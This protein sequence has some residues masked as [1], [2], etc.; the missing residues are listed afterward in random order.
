MK[1]S[2]R[3]KIPVNQIAD[4]TELESVVNRIAM[5]TINRNRTQLLMEEE[6]AAVKLQHQASLNACDTS[7]TAD[8]ELVESW[9]NANRPEFGQLKSLDLVVGKIGWRTGTPKVTP[10]KGKSFGP[11]LERLQEIHDY[12]HAVQA[13][14]DDFD[15]DDIEDQIEMWNLPYPDE[16]SLEELRQCLFDLARFSN[17]TRVIE[18]VNKE[19][20]IADRDALSLVDRAALGIQI[21]QEETFFVDPDISAESNIATAKDAKKAA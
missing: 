13:A 15:G 9:A 10:L 17:Y 20:I 5:T 12:V 2:K 21:V 19:A 1:N 18:E 3:T 8:V 14:P 16:A 7:L 11:V 6:I 4:K